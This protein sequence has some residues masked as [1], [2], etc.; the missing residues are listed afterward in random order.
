MYGGAST[1]AARMCPKSRLVSDFPQKRCTGVVRKYG[2]FATARTEESSCNTWRFEGSS[3]TSG[4]PLRAVRIKTCAVCPFLAY[5]PPRI[6]PTSIG[7]RRCPSRSSPNRS[8]SARRWRG[9]ATAPMAALAAARTSETSNQSSGLI[10]FRCA[11]TASWSRERSSCSGQH[12]RM[13]FWM[14][15][16]VPWHPGHSVLSGP[17]QGASGPPPGGLTLHRRPRH[18]PACC[19]PLPAACGAPA[20]AAA[21]PPTPPAFLAHRAYNREAPAAH[22]EGHP[23]RAPAVAMAAAAPEPGGARSCP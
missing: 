19:W 15:V 9:S 5:L 7:E 11:E 3:A 1:P 12:R 10:A 13:C 8:S 18:W 20:P 4:M 22:A 2:G 16:N 23:G 17:W 6:S 21:C 14:S